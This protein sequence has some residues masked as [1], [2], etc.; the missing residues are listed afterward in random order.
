MP[1]VF[2]LIHP[3]VMWF[4][5]VPIFSF[6]VVFTTIHSDPTEFRFATVGSNWPDYTEQEERQE[7]QRADAIKPK[8]WRAPGIKPLQRARN[9]IQ[10]RR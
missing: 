1:V 8:R 6:C 7:Q 4:S 5:N 9:W 3:Y 10:R 2:H